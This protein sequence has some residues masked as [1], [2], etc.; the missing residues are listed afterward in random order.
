MQLSILAL[1]TASL[2]AF[3]AAAAAVPS[4]ASAEVL[5]TL[6]KRT[7]TCYTS[8]GY[9]GD[10]SQKD[11]ANRLANDWCRVNAGRNYASGQQFK[12]CVSYSGGYIMFRMK[13]CRHYYI[14]FLFKSGPGFITSHLYYPFSFLVSLLL[15]LEPF[16]EGRK[17]RLTSDTTTE[18]SREH[19]LPRPGFLLPTACRDRSGMRARRSRR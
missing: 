15:F 3:Q 2:A 13:V 9:W 11:E 18:W 5:A 1:F 17:M 6:E 12:S 8:G 19:C 14:P 4:Q 16:C 10:Q 7:V